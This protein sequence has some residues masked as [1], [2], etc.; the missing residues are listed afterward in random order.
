MAA[1]KD[2]SGIVSIGLF[3]GAFAADL[4]QLPN[5][6]F[7]DMHTLFNPASNTSTS[8]NYTV[9]SYVQATGILDFGGIEQVPPFV[10]FN[11]ATI[12]GFGGD[13]SKL[14]ANFKTAEGKT[15]GLQSQYNFAN[16]VISGTNATNQIITGDIAALVLVT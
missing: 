12:T 2:F 7:V 8:V 15:D 16:D 11:P 14:L 3:T 10:P 13:Y 6:N 1:K 4:K 5:A 9:Y